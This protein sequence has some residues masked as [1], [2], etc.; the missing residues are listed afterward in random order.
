MELLTLIDQLKLQRLNHLRK[1]LLNLMKLQ[2]LLMAKNLSSP[3][4]MVKLNLPEIKSL[5]I[6]PTIHLHPLLNME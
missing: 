1:E 2:E 5:L 3:A 4:Q 6:K